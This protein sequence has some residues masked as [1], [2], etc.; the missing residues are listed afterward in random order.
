MISPALV[1]LLLIGCASP[2]QEQR[3]TE[4]YRLEALAARLET[5]RVVAE[6]QKAEAE[7]RL[8]DVETQTARDTA[9]AAER[10]EGAALALQAN[11]ASWR[12]EARAEITEVDRLVAAGKLEPD[13]AE[14]RKR[15]AIEKSQNAEQ[16]GRADLHRQQQQLDELRNRAQQRVHDAQ[17]AARRAAEN[18]ARVEQR[19]AQVIWT[20]DAERRLKPSRHARFADPRPSDEKLEWPIRC[21]AGPIS[22]PDAIEFV[23]RWTAAPIMLDHAAFATDGKSPDD[24]IVQMPDGER[25][26]RETL[27]ELRKQLHETW[28]DR[29]EQF[30]LAEDGDLLIVTTLRRADEIADAVQRDAQNGAAAELVSQS[31]P[32]EFTQNALRDVLDFYAD[33]LAVDVA[34]RRGPLE[35]H[36]DWPALRDAGVR[37]D[38]PITMAIPQVD[39]DVAIRQTL[40]QA[41]AGEP[42]A[43]RIRD[44]KLVVTTASRMAAGE[45]PGTKR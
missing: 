18:L 35:K 6:H 44:G 16:Q 41:G 36:V 28:H 3:R 29:D 27:R 43:W 34:G 32:I 7:A 13:E 10:L 30:V 5:Q 45:W 31:F 20:L 33:L 17:D 42:L 24:L 12:A 26:G 8:Q 15:A 11:A 37:P 38:T 23:S 22:L 4:L 1:A 14:T 21:R 25:S 40:L 19:L 2:R 9:Q 39:A